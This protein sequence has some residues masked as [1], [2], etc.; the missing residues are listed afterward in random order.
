MELVDI[1]RSKSPGKAEDQ[2]ILKAKLVKQGGKDY[3]KVDNSTAL[4]GPVFGASGLS[5]GA[6]I[7]VGIDQSNQLY[8]IYPAGGGG[9]N[10]YYEQPGDPYPSSPGPANI[11]AIWV[12][13]DAVLPPPIGGTG[14]DKNFVHNQNTPTDVWDIIHNL[15]KYPAVDVV[16]TGGSAVIPTIR[17]VDTNTIQLTFGSPTTGKAFMN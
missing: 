16:D 4:W 10:E 7:V 2:A 14:D 13:T 6:E 3:A 15:N 9:A 11:G 8:V 12:D 1:L 17:Y 5:S